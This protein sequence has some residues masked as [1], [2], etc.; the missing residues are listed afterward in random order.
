M[1][2]SKFDYY[3]TKCKTYLGYNQARYKH[4]T[5]LDN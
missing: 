5:L 4:F 1:V 2:F 3:P